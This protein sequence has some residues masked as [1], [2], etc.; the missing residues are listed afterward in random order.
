MHKKLVNHCTINLTII[1]DGP[2]L[3]KSGKEGADPTKPDMEFVETYHTGGRSIYLPGSSLKG[4]IR[5]HAERIVRTVGR[6]TNSSNSSLPWANDP[7]NDKYDYLKT[8]NISSCDIYK[9]S[10]FTDQMFGNTSIASRVRIEDAYPTDKTQLK[11]EERNGVAID[12]VFGSVAVGPF[13]YQV[14]T[15]GEFKT[16]IHFKNFTLAQLGLMGLVLRDLNDGWFGLGFAKSRG[17]GTVSVQYNSATVQ[18]PSCILAEDNQQISLLGSEKKWE[19]TMLL[20]AGEF[21]ER[22]EAK[23]YGFPIP[24]NQEIEETPVA[25]QLMDLGFGVELTFSGEEQVKD[26]FTRSVKAWKKLLQPGGTR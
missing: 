11:I 17:L 26:L 8:K 12:R 2:I 5:A 16:K 6:E 25:A 1:P 18:Y 10:S 19:N 22:E 14:C 4:A 9:L 3:I 21:L 13:N 15:S 7:L 23:C 24:D 20:G